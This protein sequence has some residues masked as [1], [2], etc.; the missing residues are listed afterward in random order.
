VVDQDRAAARVLSALLTEDGVQ[1]E[2]VETGDDA[3]SLLL[4]SAFDLVIAEA[5]ATLK[6]GRRLAVALRDQDVIDP[7]RIF[8]AVPELD[9]MSGEVIGHGDIT[10]VTKPFDLKQ[11]RQLV[12]LT[13]GSS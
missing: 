7:S 13:L 10:V 5:R 3:W 2:T 4:S 9:R 6:D 12:S 8:V 11:V 1:V